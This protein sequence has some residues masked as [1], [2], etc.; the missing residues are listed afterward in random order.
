MKQKKI[1]L[2]Q[3]IK[4]SKRDNKRSC[5]KNT[6]PVVKKKKKTEEGFLLAFTDSILRLKGVKKD[7]REKF[8][9]RKGDY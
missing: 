2:G 5:N 4:S 7:L 8:S 1:P 3:C 6:V 9:G